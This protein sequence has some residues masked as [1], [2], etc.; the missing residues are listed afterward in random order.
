MAKHK[1]KK[2]KKATHANPRKG[3]KWLIHATTQEGGTLKPMTRATFLHAFP[4]QRADVRRWLRSSGD[5][6]KALG[7]CLRWVERVDRGRRPNEKALRQLRK[8]KYR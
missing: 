1:A 8:K 7:G 4:E 5:Y 3:T 6:Y 2:R